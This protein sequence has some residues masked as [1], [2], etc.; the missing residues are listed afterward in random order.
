M[1]DQEKIVQEGLTKR[2]EMNVPVIIILVLGIGRGYIYLNRT[3]SI[4]ENIEKFQEYIKDE[5]SSGKIVHT[6]HYKK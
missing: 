3:N 1:A 4:D 5:K 2:T 6:D